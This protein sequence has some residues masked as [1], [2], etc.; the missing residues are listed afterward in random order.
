MSSMNLP[1]ATSWYGRHFP[2]KRVPD[3]PRQ[4]LLGDGGQLTVDYAT[5]EDQPTCRNI[6]SNSAAAGK[7]NVGVDEFSDG[8]E[9]RLNDLLIGSQ[10]FAARDSKTKISKAF[11]VVAWSPYVRCFSRLHVSGILHFGRRSIELTLLS[12]FH[13]QISYTPEN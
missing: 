5:E 13:I 4:C 3:M 10:V 9:H 11:I 12:R 1:N 2:D 7:D 6:I 8:S